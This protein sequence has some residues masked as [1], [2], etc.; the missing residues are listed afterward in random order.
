MENAQCVV[1]LA[2][3]VRHPPSCLKCADLLRL[4]RA[5]LTL[6]QIQDAATDPLIRTAALCSLV[7]ALMSLSYGIMYIVRF[8]N[9][10]SMYRA[11][12]WAEV[13]SRLPGLTG[14]CSS[15][16]N[17]GGAKDRNR[18]LLERLGLTRIAR[19]LA[20]MV[21]TRIHRCDH[22]ISLAHWCQRRV[23]PRPV[24]E[25]TVRPTHSDH[26]PVFSRAGVFCPRY[27][28]VQELW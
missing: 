12:R 1:S 6:F 22:V 8:G 14:L 26:V 19:G 13:S 23:A 24:A 25:S 7:S 9:M 10:R 4:I 3:F 18:H 16:P 11:S 27:T 28:D 15:R 17:V 21:C 20:R 5:I 2:T